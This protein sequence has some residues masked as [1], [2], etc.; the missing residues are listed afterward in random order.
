MCNDNNLLDMRLHGIQNLRS[1]F[2]C[3]R[4]ARLQGYN[5]YSIEQLPLMKVLSNALDG[6]TK[7]TA[8]ITKIQYFNIY[9]YNWRIKVTNIKTVIVIFARR[10]SHNLPF[11]ILFGKECGLLAWKSHGSSVTCLIGNLPCI[12]MHLETPIWNLSSFSIWLSREVGDW[13]FHEKGW[14]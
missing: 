13:V 10:L 11:P 9:I 14:E 12:E 2:L 6:S 8:I 7:Y 4:D 1:Y 3:E 5:A